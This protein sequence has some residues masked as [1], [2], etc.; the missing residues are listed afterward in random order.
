MP[1]KGTSTAGTSHSPAGALIADTP[2]QR[3]VQAAGASLVLSWT[4]LGIAGVQN[5]LYLDRELIP[6]PNGGA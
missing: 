2:V 4:G 5:I 6:F 3:G 1:R